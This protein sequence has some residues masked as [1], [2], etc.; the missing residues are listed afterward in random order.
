MTMMITIPEAL[1]L[2][3]TL[4]QKALKG[5]GL[6]ISTVTAYLSQSTGKGLRSVLLLHTSADAEGLVHPD[7]A[8][9]AAALEILHLATLVHDD[10]IDNSDTRRG[11]PSLHKRFDTKTAVICGDYLLAMSLSL[12]TEI[13]HRRLDA[14][15]AHL[16]MLPQVTKALGALAKG[17][18]LQHLNLGNADLHLF[19][20]LKIIS[21]KTAALFYIAAYL[22]AIIGNEPL[23]N[24]KNLGEFGRSL[25][26]AFQISDDCKDYEW[27]TET[28][29]KPVALDVS[30]KVMSLPML[31]A[32]RQNPE[33]KV[34]LKTLSPDTSFAFAQAVVKAG[35]TKEAKQLSEKYALK[36]KKHLRH[37]HGT[38]QER[39]LSIMDKLQKGI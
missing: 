18:Y 10:V 33:L 26:M 35:G 4:I 31:L 27:T 3:Q 15:D 12:L 11:L 34:L 29:G 9:A 37:T 8:T 28:A 22:G 5:S 19:T 20:Y 39:L 23:E 14:P 7:A 38:K 16:E 21:G 6:N 32:L 36:A 17:E 25:G 2:S 13:D 1:A 24:A 30:N